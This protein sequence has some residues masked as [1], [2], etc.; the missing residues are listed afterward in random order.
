MVFYETNHRGTLSYSFLLMILPCFSQVLRLKMTTERKWNAG[1]LMVLFQRRK[2]QPTPVFLPAKSHGWRSLVGYSPWGREE[3]DT[4]EWLHFTHFTHVLL[5]WRGR[6]LPT[7]C[8]ENPMDRGAWRAMLCGVAESWTRLKWVSS[9]SVDLFLS[10]FSY[11][12]VSRR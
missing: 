8:L 9:S 4:A 6:W 11:S 10:A 7:P 2:W 1:P 5:Y 12:S 3:S